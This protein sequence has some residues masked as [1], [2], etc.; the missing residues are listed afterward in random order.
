VVRRPSTSVVTVAGG[1][2]V[3]SGTAGEHQLP[4]PWL[5]D[6]LRLARHEGAGQTQTPLQGATAASLAIGD[7]VWFRHAKAGE[8]AER[9]DSYHLVR[10]ER[11][12]DT[13]PTYRG[14][15][16]TFM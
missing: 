7:L 12:M 14:D 13:A 9:F 10:G 5:P 3:A 4:S 8:L 15:G 11:L 1:G 2:Y 16:K 6:G